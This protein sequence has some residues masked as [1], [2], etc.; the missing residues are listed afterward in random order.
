MSID[1]LSGLTVLEV[2]DTLG[3]AF[4]VSLLADYNATAIV[5]EPPEGS[6]LRRLGPD[7]LS[8]MRWTILAR[9]KKSVAADW[10][11]PANHALIHRLLTHADLLVVDTVG[12][13]DN[14]WFAVLETMA[15]AERP[16]VVEVFPTGADR[17][18]LWP[19]ST[20]PEFAG[21]ASGVMALTGHTGKTP[22][23]AEAPLTDYLAGTLAATKAL[24]ALRRARLTKTAPATV[25][26]PLH[27]AVQRMIEWQTPVATVKG[28][29][30]T[31][32]ANN[33]PMNAGIAN[34]HPTDEGKYVAI[35]A[36]TQATAMRLMNMVG[37][38][39]LCADPRFATAEARS[40]GLADLY[41]Q[42]DAWTGARTTQQILETAAAQDVVLGPIYTTDDIVADEQIAAR[43][44]IVTC[45]GLPQPS[46]TPRFSGL[47]STTPTPGPAIGAN[48]DAVIELL[49]GA[50]PHATPSGG[51]P[52]LNVVELG[53]VIAGPFAGSL[54]AELGGS[55]IKVETPGAGDSLRN[56]G[57]KKDGVPI[58]FGASAREKSCVTI[59]LKHADGKAIFEKLIARA[60][61]LVEN[62]RPG[63]L[64]RLGLDWPAMSKLNPRLVMLSISG[65]GQTGPQTLRPGFGKIAEGV[66]GIVNLTGHAGQSPLFV[67]FSLADASA[68]LFGIYGVAAALYRRDVL[69]GNG[70]R[71]DVALYEPLMRMLDCQLALHSANGV[72]P[73][74]RGSNDPYS[75]GVENADRPA[76]LSVGSASGDWYLLAVSR[77]EAEGLG[78]LQDWGQTRTNAE[79]EKRLSDLRLEYAPVFDGM[80]IARS[81]YFR[82][83]GDV[84]DAEHPAIG[85]FTAAARIDGAPCPSVFRAPGLGEDNAAIFGR[86]LGM[87]AAEIER[88]TAEGVI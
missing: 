24:M 4:A 53:A 68:G 81:P 83:R 63:V 60:D 14:P 75:F 11:D 7:A 34:M 15:P 78:N 17:P 73:E 30:E 5:C 3:A 41:A 2:A 86:L 77:E 59:N 65:F 10:N 28:Q 42:I 80:T 33:F 82:A 52:E 47:E 23:H 49:D 79:I 51:K 45:G 66:S 64:E 39:E 43:G 54:M 12:N 27:Q 29:A 87:D 56:M 61:V 36:V 25:S 71:I 50:T 9:N 6:A 74:R 13:T 76:F 18:D 37:G 38:P 31:R 85:T 44:N 57:P 62:F 58:W 46:V 8:D 16:L 55:V 70:A 21:A 67:G 40:S 20:R 26:T 32:M 22:I 88:L 84:V 19:W 72:P 48:A 35:S 69:G 1:G